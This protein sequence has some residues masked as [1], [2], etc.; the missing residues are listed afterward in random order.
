MGSG[1]SWSG[2]RRVYL[3]ERRLP[4]IERF[5]THHEGASR[6][7][8]LRFNRGRRDESSALKLAW[9]HQSGAP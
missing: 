2:V 7:W 1:G 6:G 4:T 9:F 3:A 5:I 8:H